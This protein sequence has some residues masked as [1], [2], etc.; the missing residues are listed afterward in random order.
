MLTHNLVTV[1]VAT[2]SVLS[3]SAS[4]IANYLA[5]EQAGDY[6]AAE[7]Q[8]EW[9]GTGAEQLGLVGQIDRKA[10]QYL[11]AGLKPCGSRITGK[12]QPNIPGYDVTFSA[13]KSVSIAWALS[14]KEERTQIEAALTKAVQATLRDL[15]RLIPLGRRGKGGTEQIH[16]QLASALF[17]HFTN[18]EQEP[19]LHVHSIISNYLLG[20]D[21]KWSAVNSRALHNWTPALGRMFRCNLARELSA[22]L[23]MKLYRPKDESGRNKS[24]F[25]I[26]GIGRKTIE[27]F[28]SR[29]K[30]IDEL[31][32]GSGARLGKAA[33]KAR[34]RANLRTRKKKDRSLK[35]SELNGLWHDVAKECGLSGNQ[36]AKLFGKRVRKPSNK[37]LPKAL[38]AAL[39]R[40]TERKAHFSTR[41]VVREV[42]EQL[43]HHGIESRQITEFVVAQLSHSKSIIRIE[44]H[45]NEAQFTTKEMW[46]TESDF[47]SD[48][49]QLKASTRGASLRTKSI[50]NTIAKKGTLSN[51]QAAAVES[52]LS[53]K[54][55][56]RTLA[57]LAGSG[58]SYALDAVRAG[59]ESD[60]YTVIG[61]ALA[62]TAKEELTRQS[63]IEGRTVA[64]YLY[65]LDKS[66]LAR[67]KDRLARSVQSGKR[68][69]AKRTSG[70]SKFEL[71]KRHV[72]ILDEAGMLGTRQLARLVRAVKDKGAT[73]ILA[74]DPHQLNPIEAGSPFK[75]LTATIATSSLKTNRRQVSPDD[76]N[77][78]AN[79]RVGEAE[80][81]LKS[82]AKRGML[83]VEKSPH[84]ALR[85]AVSAWVLNG[86]RTRPQ[87]HLLFVQTRAEA[88]AVNQLCQRER[89]RACPS[90]KPKLKVQ[91][92][93]YYV[94]DR[95]RFNK[96]YRSRF[97]ENG[98]AG[99]VTSIKRG[100]ITVRLD[101]EPSMTAKRRG[102]SRFVTLSK[103]DIKASEMSLG[104]AATTHK[105]QGQTVQHSYLILCG[106]MTDREMAYTQATRGKLSTRLFT[107]ELS[108]GD[109]LS[110]LTKDVS[111][112]RAKKM[113]HDL[114][115]R[116]E[117]KQN[118]NTIENRI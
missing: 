9:F 63:G 32:D 4:D 33:A 46:Q 26:S 38:D 70:R 45:R 82:Y 41:E 20:D 101:Q 92:D 77:A 2:I 1:M 71:T 40:L 60:G 58:K 64:S 14:G 75:G 74:G 10:F 24:W 85:K 36:V 25:E 113:A 86:G 50:A 114:G 89:L 39:E 5:H 96:P 15:Q 103:G 57:G 52:L 3:G 49:D 108:A 115:K 98:F 21:G 118:S 107:D 48:V 11:L 97:I 72:L 53:G 83:A 87:D 94:G 79:I 19:Q 42:C 7:R 105:M 90:N 81:A 93:C 73:L 54:S 29:K 99:T 31:L 43:Q 18:R 62:G 44:S 37:L 106:G 104:F 56:I 95:V 30:A 88:R 112:S 116:K 80:S 13:P 34:E 55:Q 6:Y 51:E 69:G 100:R 23:K 111:K 8:G 91:K 66:L 78:V 68:A 109:E 59:F 117:P 22:D 61:G 17:V 16:G 76:R 65:H 12:R 28:S 67:T 102:A 27:A 35:L 84:D 110:D 47:F